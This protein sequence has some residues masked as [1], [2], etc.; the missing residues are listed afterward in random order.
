MPKTE[1]PGREL[2]HS[3][4]TF[5]ARDVNARVIAWVA[6]GIVVAAVLIHLFVGVVYG[7]FSRAE[8][9]GR[10]PVTLVRQSARPVTL[11]ALQVKPNV[12]LERLQESEKQT[13]TS[14]GW[15]DQQKGIVRIPVEE[16]MKRVLENGLPA[17]EKASPSPAGSVVIEQ[18]KK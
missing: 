6:A 14:Y 4:V 10:Q 3:E 17:A 8:F 12:D 7:Y 2:I 13:L 16:A 9:R 15:V 1:K 5:E 11:P 18:N